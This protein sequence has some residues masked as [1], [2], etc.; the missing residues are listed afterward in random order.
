MPNLKQ[1]GAR[2]R[3]FNNEVFEN[4]TKNFGHEGTP[5]ASIPAGSG[6]VINSNDQVEIFNN[7]IRDNKTA[8]IIVSSIFS[9]GYGDGETQ[10]DFDPYP[11]EIFIYDN[12]FE[13]G[14]N[15]PD[16]LDLQALKLVV[17]G[18]MGSLPDIL[19]DGY[20]NPDR[21]SRAPVLCVQNGDAEVVNVDGPNGNADPG[22]APGE[23]DCAFEKLPAVAL[24]GPLAEQM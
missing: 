23:H 12:A 11:E 18:P 6:V 9:A 24:T 13:G 15:N 20:V 22:I 7:D 2:T 8:N 17:S 1:P 14:G 19:W 4:N 21:D 16:G 5:V 10:D 3:I